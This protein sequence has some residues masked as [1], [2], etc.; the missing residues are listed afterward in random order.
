MIATLFAG[1]QPPFG[2]EHAK[3]IAQN[4]QHR[5]RKHLDP[6]RPCRQSHDHLHCIQ[7]PGVALKLLVEMWHVLTVRVAIRE[8]VRELDLE[9]EI[10]AHIVRARDDSLHPSDRREFACRELQLVGTTTLCRTPASLAGGTG[11]TESPTQLG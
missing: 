11:S 8:F 3:I 1:K 7:V 5:L 6:S 2:F 9:R 4:S 10:V